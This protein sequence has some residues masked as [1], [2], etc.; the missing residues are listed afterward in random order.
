MKSINIRRFIDKV[1]KGK[2]YQASTETEQFVKN[3]E[4]LAGQTP[5]G[6]KI[7]RTCDPDGDYTVAR[8]VFEYIE[9][10]EA[11][12]SVLPPPEAQKQPSCNCGRCPW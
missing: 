9:K 8:L 10:P 1:P 6:F 4:F 3:A 5:S 2:Y 12:S 11:D 7:E